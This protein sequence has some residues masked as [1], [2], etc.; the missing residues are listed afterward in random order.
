[1]T[2][3]GTVLRIPHLQDSLVY[4]ALFQSVKNSSFLRQQLIEGNTTYEYAFLDASTI[5]STTHVLAACFR[6][7]NDATAN[8]LRTRNVH[9]EIVFALSPNNNIA[10]SFRRFGVADETTSLLAIKV[11]P[12]TGTAAGDSSATDAI[13]T[14][15]RGAVEGEPAPFTDE[16][17]AGLSDVTRIRKLYKAPAPGSSR[18]KTGVNG[19]SSSL[20]ELK[21]L[22]SI[23]IGSMAIKGS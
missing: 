3:P 15:L 5:L 11:I 23:I 4:V 20:Q 13:A 12:T 1:M 16:A 18:K 10:E 7:I 14:H 9:S 17:F 6:A 2:N 8:R 19:T 21:S 22:E